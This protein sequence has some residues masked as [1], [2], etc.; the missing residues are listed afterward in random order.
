MR[1][2]PIVLLAASWFFLG[3]LGRGV[4]ADPPGGGEVKIPSLPEQ[5]RRQW[6]IER[7]EPQPESRGYLKS[8][9]ETVER[10]SLREAIATALE[11]NPGISVERLGP[12]FARAGIDRAVGVFDP[13]F[14][15]YGKIQRDVTPTG[16]ALA[17]ATALRQRQNI[18]GFTLE[19]LVR[20]GATL[21]AN[22]DS[23]ELDSNS[24]FFGLRP[25][26][27]PVLTFSVAQPLLRNFGI[28]LTILL[29]RSAEASAS[30]AYYEYRSRVVA[31]VRQVVEAY[32]G[33][34]Q[35][36]ETLKAE[37]DGLRLAQTLEKENRARV[38]AGV[39]PPIAVKEAAAE[40]ARR[41][42]RVIVA[43]NAAAIAS[44]RLR[45]LLQHNPE[46]AFLPRPI[47]PAD[48]PEVRQVETDEQEILEEAING[49]P[50]VL[51]ARY[52]IENR[53]IL[54]KVKRN[55]LLPG[56]DLNASYGLNGLSGRGVPQT[57][58]STG[59]TAV[60]PFAGNYE[61]SLDRLFSDDFNSYTAGLTLTVPLANATAEA[62]YAQ[63]QIDLRRA[64]L[65]YRQLLS[66]VTL[67]VRKAV[68]DVRSNSK[69]I[70][71][72]RL[73]R[74]LAEENLAQERKRLEVGLATTKDI[75]DFQEKLTTARAAEIQALIDYN[76]ALAA[77]RQ[78]DGTLLKQFDVVL[79]QLPP[80]PT[81][82]WARF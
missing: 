70:T 31:L 59:R 78:A 54:A 48:S 61:S 66:D 46:G 19:K 10:L 25:Q 41:E 74:E 27:K 13:S 17:G 11:N 71:A 33:V 77:L 29:V 82:L 73:A 52:D 36:R 69:R 14:K 39:L 49:R 32:W 47:E 72:S 1:R 56:L 37:E 42:E 26:Y 81:P 15:T 2:S 16:T 58:L 28:D 18:F 44:D 62:E 80:S 57:D 35:A 76:V 68:G 55:N 20:T 5:L 22:F 9:D 60:S 51:R 65:T 38:Q 12:S 7:I 63:S 50:E 30:L 43:A 53:K 8:R 24:R 40:A 75:L 21:T 64:E 67:E 79:E 3:A 34:V 45:L 6:T 4:L 23:N